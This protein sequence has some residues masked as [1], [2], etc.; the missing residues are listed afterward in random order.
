VSQK[1]P[2]VYLAKEGLRE[3]YKVHQGA[4]RVVEAILKV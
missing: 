2:D 4:I 1:V 3:P